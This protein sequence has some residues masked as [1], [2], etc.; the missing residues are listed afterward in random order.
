M[1]YKNIFTALTFI[2][3]WA[4]LFVVWQIHIT[5]DTGNRYQ[6]VNGDNCVILLDKRTGNTW[7]NVWNNNNEK[8]PTDWELMN[9]H[10]EYTDIPIGEQLR[11]NEMIKRN[12]KIRQR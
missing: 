8:L 12:E 4:I 2:T 9:Q 5:S 11:R 3:V 6:I 1:N 10:G 7:R